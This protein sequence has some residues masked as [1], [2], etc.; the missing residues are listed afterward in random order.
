TRSYGDWSSDVCSS[1]LQT[2]AVVGDAGIGK[3]RLVQELCG[4]PELAEASI[5]QANCHE[6]FSN[7]PLYPLVSYLWARIGL[8][9]EDDVNVRL[10]KISTF[11]NEL[12]LNTPENNQ[13]IANLLGLV[14]MGALE[15]VA[16]TSLLL[17]R[18]QYDFVI[19]VLRT[20]ARTQS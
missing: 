11:L 7:T 9:L 12:A 16:P 20:V 19:N 8:A 5:L 1:D 14:S 10:Q 4:Q 13:L 18:K 6:L 17:K 15:S 2:V 3:T